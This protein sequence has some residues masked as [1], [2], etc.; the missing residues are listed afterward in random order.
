MSEQPK[1]LSREF[2]TSSILAPG[3][4]RGAVQIQGGVAKTIHIETIIPFT[5]L[6]LT[7]ILD[8]AERKREWMLVEILGPESERM[9]RMKKTITEEK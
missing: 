1:G 3:I 6:S 7:G 5:P 4:S 8:N 9:I 2:V